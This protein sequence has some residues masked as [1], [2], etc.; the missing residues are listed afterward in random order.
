MTESA[1]A[2]TRMLPL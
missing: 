1:G 2:G